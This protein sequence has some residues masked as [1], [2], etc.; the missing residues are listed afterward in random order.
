MKIGAHPLVVAV[1]LGLLGPSALAEDSDDEIVGDRGDAC[2]GCTCGAGGS[3]DEP[4]GS[5]G[6]FAGRFACLAD[7]SL[8]VAPSTG[9]EPGVDL[10]L[11]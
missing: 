10:A 3:E 7:D 9:W 4:E 11:P 2:E 8:D 5:E 6:A 1:A